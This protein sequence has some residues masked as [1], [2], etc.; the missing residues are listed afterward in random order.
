MA[1]T[2]HARRRAPV[3]ALD[4]PAI[5]YIARMSL[6]RWLAMVVALAVTACHSPSSSSSLP[7]PAPTTG[8]IFG[9][10]RDRVTGSPIA[11][12]QVT[13]RADGELEAKASTMSAIEGAYTFDGL[14]P[15]R[16]SLTAYFAGGSVEVANVDVVAGRLVAVDIA[17]ELGRAEKVV[18]DFGDAKAG[19]I[20]RYR[21]RSA[22]ARTGVIEGT[23]NDIATRERVPGAVVTAI[24]TV[25][26]RIV[27]ENALQT[28]TDDHGRFKLDAVTPGVYLVSAYYTIQRRGLIEV[29]RNNVDVR[30]GEAVVV[31]LYIELEQ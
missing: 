30:G 23:V 6:G 2:I 8:S 12:A 3:C 11:Q 29:Q 14:R 1:R 7:P 5:R 15:G 31:P 16:Y 20:D 24:V 25:D 22:D 28:V 19:A 4:R 26:G 18:L 17:F 10:V 27:E 13:L 21:P 9:L